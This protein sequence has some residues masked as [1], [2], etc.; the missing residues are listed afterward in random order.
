[1]STSKLPKLPSTDEGKSSLR[2]E[3][4]PAIALNALTDI[5]QQVQHYQ[6]QLR[7]LVHKIQKI[8]AE[9]PV[10]SGWLASE[11]SLSAAVKYS[12]CSDDCLGSLPPG[13]PLG[14]S[15]RNLPDAA[16]GESPS[17]L[18]PPSRC[19]E[20]LETM[21]VALFRHGDANDLM[22]YL[23]A[24]ES[25]MLEK[26]VSGSHALTSSQEANGRSPARLPVHT[27]P[28]DRSGEQH[29]GQSYYL[30]QLNSSGQIQAELCPPD[31]VP[32]LSMAIARYRRLN[33]LIKQK[34]AIETKLQAIVAILGDA[35][36]VLVE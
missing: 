6:G 25:A 11:A 20:P 32:V 3:V 12:H 24:L 31:Q 16:W 21:D 5:Y 36:R 7:Q 1:M 30:C 10:V 15:Q 27:A 23:S 28:A 14:N 33:Q 17:H 8:Y 19:S 18:D 22:N 4:N 13:D 9:G 35:Q 26:G 29:S 34:Q 2:Y